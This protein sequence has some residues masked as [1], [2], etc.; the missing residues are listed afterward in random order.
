MGITILGFKYVTF[1]FSSTHVQIFFYISFVNV[2]SNAWLYLTVFWSLQCMLISKNINLCLQWM[3][4]VNY[5]CVYNTC[6]YLNILICVYSA[7]LYLTIFVST[8]HVSSL[9][10]M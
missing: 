8:M 5:I 1:P 4:T 6:L 2:F 7:C 3:F 9:Y 10:S